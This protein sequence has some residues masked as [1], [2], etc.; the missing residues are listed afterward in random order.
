MG[1][2]GMSLLQNAYSGREYHDKAP[3]KKISQSTGHPALY[4]AYQTTS[5]GSLN[6]SSVGVLNLEAGFPAFRCFLE[7][8]ILSLNVPTKPCLLAEPNW[9]N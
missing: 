6:P 1:K 3:P 5:T 4:L 8:A 2:A 9:H 7:V